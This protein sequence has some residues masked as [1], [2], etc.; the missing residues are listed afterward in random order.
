MVP[1]NS[2]PDDI[3]QSL[4]GLKAQAFPR[5]SSIIAQHTRFMRRVDT[6]TTCVVKD[7]ANFAAYFFIN[8][9]FFFRGRGKT[10]INAIN[11]I[12]ETRSKP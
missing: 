2:T 3:L 6:L 4:L 5:F 12:P 9:F 11:F 1:C 7:C 10:Q 8:Q